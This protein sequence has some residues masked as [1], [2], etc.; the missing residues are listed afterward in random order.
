MRGTV[1]PLYDTY[2][3]DLMSELMSLL[4]CSLLGMHDKCV[5]FTNMN[6]GFS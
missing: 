3:I 4:I 1:S 2:L 6:V 5:K